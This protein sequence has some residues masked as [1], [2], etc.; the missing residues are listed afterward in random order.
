MLGERGVRTPYSGVILRRRWDSRN[1]CEMKPKRKGKKERK[2]E[3]RKADGWL[4]N[5]AVRTEGF[6][7]SESPVVAS[8][9]GPLLV[10]NLRR[11][12]CCL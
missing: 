6:E 7:C 11:N 2:R 4:V 8:R 1:G 9:R 3:K 5:D 12:A 10:P